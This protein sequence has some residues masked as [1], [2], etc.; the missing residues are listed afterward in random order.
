VVGPAGGLLLLDLRLRFRSGIFHHDEIGHFPRVRWGLT[1]VRMRKAF[2]G[3]G[4]RPVAATPIP[5]HLDRK[6]GGLLGQ[7]VES[8]QGADADENPGKWS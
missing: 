3:I 1:S 2:R 4:T 5:F 8:P 6:I 7:G